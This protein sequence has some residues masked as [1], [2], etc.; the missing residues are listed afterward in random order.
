MAMRK[1]K[2]IK[3]ED[4]FLGFIILYGILYPLIIAFIIYMSDEPIEDELVSSV[5]E[6]F[7]EGKCTLDGPKGLTVEKREDLERLT[8]ICQRINQEG[9]DLRTKEV[10]EGKAIL[11]YGKKV[12][13]LERKLI[14]ELTIEGEK[15]TGIRDDEK[16]R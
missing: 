12:K 1:H 13:G 9:F 11:Y 7:E 2:G 14:I 4:V 5:V 6:Y 3:I 8:A 10:E 16:G 15:I